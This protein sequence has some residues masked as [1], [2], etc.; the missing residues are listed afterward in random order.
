MGIWPSRSRP[1]ARSIATIS[2]P[3]RLA[4]P[5]FVIRMRRGR[6]TFVLAH[7]VCDHHDNVEPM[8]VP[9]LTISALLAE[10]DACALALADTLRRGLTYAELRALAGR[11][12]QILNQSGLKAHDTVAVALRNGP[13]TAALF[14]ALMTY[15]RVAPINPGY[16]QNEIAF[17]LRDLHASAIITSGDV[18]EALR[19]AEECSVRRM[20]MVS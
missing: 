10:P 17:A 8:G 3:V 19:A 2:V 1:D 11:T 5:T 4:I 14:I 16:T 20:L 18:P 6:C 9:I 7:L 12:H 13:E 15:C